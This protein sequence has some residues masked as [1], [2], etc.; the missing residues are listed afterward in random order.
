MGICRNLSRYRNRPVSG[1]DQAEPAALPLLQHH[2]ELSP[3]KAAE[4]TDGKGRLHRKEPLPVGSEEQ[5]GIPLGDGKNISLKDR[6]LREIRAEAVLL[7]LQHICF[8]RFTVF[9]QNPEEVPAQSLIPGRA[10]FILP[11]FKAALHRRIA[12]ALQAPNRPDPGFREVFLP[13]FPVLRR[14]KL[15]V[16]T[17][18]PAPPVRQKRIYFIFRNRI[19][20]VIDKIRVFQQFLGNLLP[21]DPVDDDQKAVAHRL[22]DQ[23]RLFSL[24]DG[25]G[26]N[27]VPGEDLPCH[28]FR[29][30]REDRRGIRRLRSADAAA[31]GADRQQAGGKAPARGCFPSFC[32][33]FW[34][35][36]Y[37]LSHC[38][39][40]PDDSG[41][42]HIIIPTPLQGGKPFFSRRQF[43]PC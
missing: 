15:P 43:P 34:S 23:D 39:P 3:A 21:E 6:E 4:L 31:Q 38:H 13:V 27:L 37:S 28:F 41:R 19:T 35:V 33:P 42:Y 9:L 32:F 22:L 26:L 17:E 14:L 30:G 40:R 10:G 1:V 2:G 16:V 18:Q 7:R 24:A 29:T 20:P 12:A 5:H 8:K 25:N 11:A 36:F